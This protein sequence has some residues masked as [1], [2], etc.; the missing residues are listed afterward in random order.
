M[1]DDSWSLADVVRRLDEFRDARDWRQFHRPKELAAAIAI[2]AG[3]LQELFLWKN[4]ESS[5]EVAED[6]ARLQRIQ[7]EVADVGIFLLLLAHELGIDL[8][9]AMQRKIEANES[10]YD[11]LASKGRWD[12]QP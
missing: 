4:A 3:E 12:K 10:R 5:E 9:A 11:V 1:T 6:G 7:E 2:E 8:R